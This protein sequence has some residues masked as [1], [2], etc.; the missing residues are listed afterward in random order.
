MYVEATMDLNEIIMHH[1][2]QP[3][4]AKEKNLVSITEKVTTRYFPVYEKVCGRKAQFTAIGGLG[5]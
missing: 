1:P 5:T 3:P 4:E 2:L